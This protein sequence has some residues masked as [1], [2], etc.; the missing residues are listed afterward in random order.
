M[1]FNLQMPSISQIKV[2]F[3]GKETYNVYSGPSFS[4]FEDLQPCHFTGLIEN[5]PRYFDSMDQ[6]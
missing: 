3:K 2:K 5:A 1:H 4:H 6:T